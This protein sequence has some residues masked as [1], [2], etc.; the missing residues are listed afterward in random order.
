M[1]AV[2]FDALGFFLL[3]VLVNVGLFWLCMILFCQSR[4]LRE[5]GQF[6]DDGGQV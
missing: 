3:S 2:I 1:V 4:L 5:F 6:R